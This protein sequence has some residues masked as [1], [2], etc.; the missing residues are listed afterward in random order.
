MATTLVY[1]FSFLL[2]IYFLFIFVLLGVLLVKYKMGTIHQIV[3]NVCMTL[4]VLGSMSASMG[5]LVWPARPL[6]LQPDLPLVCVLHFS[7]GSDAKL[8]QT[9]LMSCLVA[10]IL[11]SL[12]FL[13]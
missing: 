10:K 12:L 5:V 9:P 2:F 11:L 6:G 1:V 4:I 8:S 3:Q 7:M 13:H